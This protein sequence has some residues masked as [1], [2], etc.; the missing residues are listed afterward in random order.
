MGPVVSHTPQ[1]VRLGAF[2]WPGDSRLEPVWLGEVGVE[3]AGR[4]RRGETGLRVGGALEE[5]LHRAVAPPSAF[6]S[7][8]ALFPSMSNTI[9]GT[10]QEVLGTEK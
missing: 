10:A 3:P 5:Q 2:S 8:A 7:C 6:G 4:G 9:T 1:S